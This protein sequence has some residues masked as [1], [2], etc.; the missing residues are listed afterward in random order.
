[1]GVAKRGASFSAFLSKRWTMNENTRPYGSRPAETQANA[2][3]IEWGTHDE[4][5][6]HAQTHRKPHVWAKE[7]CEGEG[8]GGGG[9]DR[10]RLHDCFKHLAVARD[11]HRECHLRISTPQYAPHYQT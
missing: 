9:V 7:E 3:I 5:R 2:Q 11:A 4:R 10:G 6:E 8:N 1:M